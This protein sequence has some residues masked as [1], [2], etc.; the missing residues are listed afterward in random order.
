VVVLR[1]ARV[2]CVTGSG[3]IHVSLSGPDVVSPSSD[4]IPFWRAS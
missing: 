4:T 2:F 3:E 1:C